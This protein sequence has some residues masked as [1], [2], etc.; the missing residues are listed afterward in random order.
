M[1]TK[2]HQIPSQVPLKNEPG[3]CSWFEC[4]SCKQIKREIDRVANAE[5]DYV[6]RGFLYCLPPDRI[7]LSYC[8]KTVRNKK[9]LDEKAFGQLALSIRDNEKRQKAI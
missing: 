3:K 7:K 2:A 9:H 4:A 6:S 5:T 8:L 1:E